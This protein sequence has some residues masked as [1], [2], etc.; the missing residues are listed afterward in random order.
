MPLKLADFYNTTRHARKIIV[1]D[2]GFLGDSVHLAPALWELKRH[3]PAAALH[4]VS[5]PVGAEV[6]RLAACVD[7]AWAFP[8]GPPS[9][10]WWRHWGLLRALRRERYDLALNFSGADRTIFV[11]AATGARWR[12]AHRGE[13]DHFWNRWLIPHWAPRQGSD[14]PVFEQRRRV[15]AVC[16]MELQAPRFD[17]RPPADAVKWAGEHVPPGAIHLSIN[18]SAALKEWPLAHWI[19][20]A[21]LL[22]EQEPACHL[23][24]TGS[25]HPREQDRLRQLAGAVAHERL[26]V[27]PPGLPIAQLAAALARCRLHVGADSGVLH[28]AMALGVPTF[29]IFRGYAGLEEWRPHGEA[30]RHVAVPCPCADRRDPP[31]LEK[32][33]AECLARIAPESVAAAVPEQLASAR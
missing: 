23:I 8:L 24:A 21:R 19:A 31:C 10:P 9:P 30:H 5:A 26:R 17:L 11:T 1:V 16:G 13:R 28:L 12:V 7:R 4:V 25:A 32:A 29:G 22:L 15:L 2:L 20:L 27:L 6:L 3:Y 33:A 18:A 14:A